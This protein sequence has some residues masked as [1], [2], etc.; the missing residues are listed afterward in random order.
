MI[1]RGPGAEYVTYNGADIRV[2]EAIQKTGAELLPFYD[3][4]V[5]HKD[6]YVVHG[7]ESTWAYEGLGVI[8]LTNE[9]WA[10]GR[11]YAKDE[12]PS[13]E[14]YRK[15][16][17][18][19]QFGDV[20]VPYHEIEHPTY[21]TILVGGTTKYSSRI[22]PPWMLEEGCH[23][24]FAFT[25]YHADQMGRGPVGDHRGGH[26]REDHPDDPR[27]RPAEEDRRPRRHH[28]HPRRRE[29]GGGVGNGLVA[30]ARREAG[31]GEAQPAADLE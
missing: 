29:Q 14:E 17:D 30:A 23:R 20:Y 22:T 27:S 2:F 28:V 9:L 15:F 24:N 10:G 6:L 11:M 25:M 16:R 18:L 26:Q 3:V 13:T 12:R 1:L 7:G 19:L 31:R 5:L 8:G 21:G 4:M